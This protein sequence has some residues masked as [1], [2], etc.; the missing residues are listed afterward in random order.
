MASLSWFLPLVFFAEI[1]CAKSSDKLVSLECLPEN[2]GVYGQNTLLKCEV[3]SRQEDVRVIMVFWKRDGSNVLTFRS[4]REPNPD[5]RFQLLKHSHTDVSL[6]LKNT[7]RTD[8]GKYECTVITDSGEDKKEMSLKVTAPYTKPTMGSIPEKDIDDDTD[9]T[10]YCNASGGYPLGMIHWFDQFGTNWTRSAV[11]TALETEDKRINL[12]SK[13]TLK[14]SSVHPGYRCSVLN[15]NGVK[16]GETEFQ[17]M[18]QEKRKDIR[19]DKEGAG[20]SPTAIAA[21][22]VVVGSLLCGL[23]ILMIIRR[24]RFHHEQYMEPVEVTGEVEVAL[25]GE[26]KENV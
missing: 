7:L 16:E 17:L 18:F 26:K 24:R 10:L 22:V 14:A 4:G 13:F 15:S 23:L 6:L 8:E 21:V 2:H 5:A 19:P 3:K 11:T 20:N 12:V 9:V 1:M 25:T